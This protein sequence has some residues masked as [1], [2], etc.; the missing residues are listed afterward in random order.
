M[1]QGGA[2]DNATHATKARAQQHATYVFLPDASAREALDRDD[3]EERIEQEQLK[4]KRVPEPVLDD[5]VLVR[6]GLAEED[7]DRRR[8]PEEQ[9]DEC[10]RDGARLQD[11]EVAQVCGQTADARH[12]EET[13]A[14]QASPLPDLLQLARPRDAVAG[15]EGAGDLPEPQEHLGV[16]RDLRM[17]QDPNHLVELQ[18]DVG[19]PVHAA[20]AALLT[21]LHVLAHRLVIHAPVLD[22]R[23]PRH[24]VPEREEEHE[25]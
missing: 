11:L 17:H 6:V 25:R 23:P 1:S 13:E 14:E 24:G 16:R 21:L 18:V 10:R 5:F 20:Q 3:G 4:H 12:V 8:D 9:C 7:Q 2:Q 15:V 22:K 19:A